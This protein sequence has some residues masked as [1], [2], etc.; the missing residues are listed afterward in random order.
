MI[1]DKLF[2]CIEVT[3]HNDTMHPSNSKASSTQT[4]IPEW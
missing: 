4:N 1:I 3:K 2:K